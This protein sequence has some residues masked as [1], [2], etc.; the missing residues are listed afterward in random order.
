MPTPI[1]DISLASL[2]LQN[3]SLITLCQ[4][5][6]NGFIS[7]IRGSLLG[8]YPVSQALILIACHCGV[9]LAH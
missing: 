5:N 2:S 3:T 1:L 4:E 8:K 6:I 7:G 9:K